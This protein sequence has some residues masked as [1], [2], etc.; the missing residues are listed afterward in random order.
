MFLSATPDW[1]VRSLSSDNYSLFAV[2]EHGELL[3]VAGGED[4]LSDLCVDLVRRYEARLAFGTPS[5]KLLVA[6]QFGRQ[7]NG[8]TARRR[9]AI[10]ITPNAEDD[11]KY[12][13]VDGRA[14]WGSTT[15][16]H[17]VV[18][19]MNDNGTLGNRLGR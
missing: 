14:G 9:Y 5:T 10:V 19:R 18:R 17:V 4:G 13:P 8:T 2:Y 3:G 7:R 6:F 12:N 15:E 11:G 16:H 1:S